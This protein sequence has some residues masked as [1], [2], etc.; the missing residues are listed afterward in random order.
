MP[1]IPPPADPNFGDRVRQNLETL[2]GRRVGQGHYRRPTG[3]VPP[4]G[5]FANLT[6]AT[7]AYID[8][9]ESVN[10]IIDRLQ[11]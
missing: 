8:L 4:N 9:A 2:T 11:G 6:Q 5:V 10:D 7:Q 1:A 3:T